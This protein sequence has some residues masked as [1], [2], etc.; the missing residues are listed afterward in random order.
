M[1]DQLQSG[2]GNGFVHIAVCRLIVGQTV[3][4]PSDSIARRHSQLHQPICSNS[5][6]DSCPVQFR[7][8]GTSHTE[9][10]FGEFE[11]VFNHA[12]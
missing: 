10:R 5:E 4:T 8:F 12:I 11:V 9:L 3:S 1:C 7:Q 2:L 6:G